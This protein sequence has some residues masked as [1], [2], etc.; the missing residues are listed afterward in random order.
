VLDLQNEISVSTLYTLKC[1]KVYDCS[2]NII[3][4]EGNTLTFALPEK[5][6]PGD[7]VV[8]E[9]LFNPLPLGVDFVEV[10]NTS[11]KFINLKDWSLANVDG[12]SLKN[13][14]IIT[15]DDVLLQPGQYLVFTSDGATLKGQYVAAIEQNFLETTLPSLPDDEG[16]IVIVD[17]EANI[18]D[19]FIYSDDM[20]SPFI[21][22]DDGVSLERVSFSAPTKDRQ[23]WKSG[24]SSTGY[25]T[26]GYLNANSR[27]VE[28]STETIEVSPE[29]FEPIH[30][31]PDFAQIQYKFD[32][33]GYVAN[34]KIY[35]GQG[36]LIKQL[37]NNDILGTEGF[38][39]WDGDRD[40]GTKARIGYYFVWFQV[41]N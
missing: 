14:R 6:S 33:G 18:V 5:A 39:R 2:G 21:K 19:Q 3:L 17:E 34:V 35:D 10:C 20:H 40:D 28:T 29:V 31:Q 36:R 16:S 13:K 9:L 1:E 27:P 7:V 23:N 26:P 41:F 37:A 8:N 25:A 38:Y 12:D 15:K 32:Q 4:S 11:S 30:G 22:D 24:T